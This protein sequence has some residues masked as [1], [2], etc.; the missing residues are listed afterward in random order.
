MKL[1]LHKS[2]AVLLLLCTFAAALVLCAAAEVYD[3]TCG[4]DLTYTLDTDTGVL[5]ISGMGEMTDNPWST[6][7]ATIRTVILE[8]GVSSICNRA[9]YRCSNLTNVTLPDSLE[10][11]CSGAFSYC[12]GLT[13]IA[14]P[15]SVTDIGQAAF[16]GSKLVKL[17][18]PFVGASRDA[19]TQTEQL[20]L[21]LFTNHNVGDT[22]GYRYTYGV[23]DLVKYVPE[24]LTQVT[25][26]G[27]SAI[28]EKAFAGCK[29]I[30]E[31]TIK[32]GVYRIGSYAFE[33]CTSLAK[34]TMEDSVS[35]AI[36]IG[37]GAFYGCSNLA[38][39]RLPNCKIGTLGGDLFH[40]CRSLQ[41]IVIPEGV[42]AIG[43]NAFIGCTNLSSVTLPTG[44]ASIARY[45]FSSCTSLKK[46][47]IPDTVQSIAEYAFSSCSGLTEMTLPFAPSWKSIFGTSSNY[48]IPASLKKITITGGTELKADAFYDLRKMT[49]LTIPASVTEIARTAFRSCTRLKTIHIDAENPAYTFTSGMLIDKRDNRVIYAASALS[50]ICA[51][52]ETVACIGELGFSS[53]QTLREVHLPANVEKIEASAFSGCSSLTSISIYNPNCEIADSTDTIPAATAIYGFTGSTAEAYAT[54]YNREFIALTPTS[55]TAAASAATYSDGTA[56]LR[57]TATPTFAGGL[58]VERY[59]VFFAPAKYADSYTVNGQVV[60]KEGALASGASFSAD[61]TDIPESAYDVKIYAWAFVKV[62]GFKDLVVCPTDPISIHELVK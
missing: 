34:V 44:L 38:S 28:L 35:R 9:F 52:P 45:A 32:N 58:T 56:T 43:E 23:A 18:I 55:L 15:E 4:D 31:V 14:V 2:F 39:A 11:I 16:E 10:I 13:E 24:S 27:A 40:G 57:V 21:Y 20:F 54:K 17:T 19:G 37:Q 61:L 3:G 49:D 26:S 41:E 1:T 42:T 51:V 47:V 33:E 60:S 46:I 53:C 8:D 7:K 50:G 30:E 48:S 25:I 36:S 29:Y 22:Y 62:A 59:G 6:Q 12:T 5:T